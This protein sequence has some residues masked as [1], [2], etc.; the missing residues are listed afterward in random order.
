MNHGISFKVSQLGLIVWGVFSWLMMLALL[1]IIG[2]Q[3]SI[4]MSEPNPHILAVEI[5]AFFLLAPIA[6]V[7]AWEYVK[8][9]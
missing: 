2:T 6:V 8:T 5:V 3:G 9:W 4:V 1:V 7:S